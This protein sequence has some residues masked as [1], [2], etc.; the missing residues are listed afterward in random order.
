MGINNAGKVTIK[1][2]GQVTRLGFG[3]MRVTGEGIW[4]EPADIDAAHAVV[5]RAVDLGVDFIDT[6][7]SYGPEVSERILAD[8]LAPYPDGLRIGT[9]A[10]Q[11]R[12]GP[13]KWV[14][15]GRAP[16]LRQQV[17]LSLRR[18]K[19]DTL[20]LF[21]LHRIDPQVEMAE[22]FEVM[23]A[24]QQEGKARAL[25]LSQVSV[26]EIQEAEKYFTVA[27]VQ[28]RYNISDRRDD[29]V[30]EYCTENGIAFIPWAPLDAGKLAKK[31]GPVDD[32]AARLGVSHSQVALA[33][34][35]ERSPMML[36]IPGTSSV[37]NLESN[38]AAADVRLDD[39][40]LAEL[41]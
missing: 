40:A 1:D 17:E 35:L 23:A 4:G 2:L 12:P 25:G 30:V 6:A 39:E 38:V 31:G 16:Y 33:W 3:A 36:P 34:L 7:D 26:A 21:Q 22:Q 41:G 18:L 37:K 32:V 10:G 29:D 28:N 14:P 5:R 13:G 9:K 8:V 27:S 15:V 24:L 20:D 19:V 11:T